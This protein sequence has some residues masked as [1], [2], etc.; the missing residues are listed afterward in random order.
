M[1]DPKDPLK[2]FP[3]ATPDA[4]EDGGTDGPM[5]NALMDLIGK[6][7]AEEGR[8]DTAEPIH[9]ASKSWMESLVSKLAEENWVDEDEDEDEDDKGSP[10]Q[11]LYL[12]VKQPPDPRGP[13]WGREGDTYECPLSGAVIHTQSGMPPDPD[14]YRANGQPLPS[15]AIWWETLTASLNWE[16]PEC[17][18]EDP[19][20]VEGM[21]N[22]ASRVA[23]V[24]YLAGHEE[25]WKAT[26]MLLHKAFVARAKGTLVFAADVQGLEKAIDR[27][28]DT[29]H[30]ALGADIATALPREGRGLPVGWY[31]DATAPAWE[32]VPLRAPVSYAMQRLT[33]KAQDALRVLREYNPD[34]QVSSMTC[35]GCPSSARCPWAFDPYNTNGDCLAEK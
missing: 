17:E 14:Y 5:L 32:G 34:I 7:V 21:S 3:P 28:W 13:E 19:Y 20:S 24:A 33:Q 22:I 12:W 15:P 16:A 23:H 25:P 11:D 18:A 10:F 31:Y 27:A 29:Y 4:E 9:R 2:G 30:E 35:L 6:K 8:G 26:A 1:P